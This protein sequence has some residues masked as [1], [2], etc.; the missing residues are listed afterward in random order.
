MKAQWVKYDGSDERI[1]EMCN[2]KHG[3]V[4]KYEDGDISKAISFGE[5]MDMECP[6][7]YLICDPHP[8]A[9]MICQWARTGQPVYVKVSGGI[10]PNNSIFIE[11]ELII[12]MPEYFIIK[13]NKPNWNIPN[14]D[15]SFT[16]FE[17]EV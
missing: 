6:M 13:T 9:E 15:Y 12:V 4:V 1:A 2:A 10:V 8:Y 16:P 11:D 14:V 17:E 7:E 5:P 3:W